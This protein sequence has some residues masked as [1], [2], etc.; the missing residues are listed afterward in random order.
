MDTNENTPA[1]SAR[2]PRLFRWALWGGLG[3]VVICFAI[4]VVNAYINPSSADGMSGPLMDAI[5]LSIYQFGIWPIMIYMGFIGPIIEE[6]TCR[7][8][9]NGK[10][11]TGITS[12]ALMTFSCYSIGWWLSLLTVLCGVAILVFF[13]GDKTK[14]LFVLMLFSSILFAVGHEGNY[15]ENEGWLMWLVALFDKFGFGLV[16]SYLVINHN[17]LWSMGL[18]ILHNSVIALMYV[19]SFGQVSNSVVTIDNENFHLEVQPV[20]VHNDSIRQDKSFFNDADTN[21]YFGSTANFAHQAM[22][23]EA[24]QNGADPNDSL[25]FVPDSNYPKCSFTLVYKKQPFDHHGLIVA[26]EKEGLIKIDTTTTCIGN[27]RKTMLNIKST[28]DPL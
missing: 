4:M 13:R 6:V 11:W 15:D 10:L 25:N 18:H 19:M 9:G 22:I 14:R 1:V 24:W 23:Y 16:A 26:M 2:K 17:I 28:Y 27:N 3:I 20:L 12:I 5:Y 21:Y 8:W 7:L